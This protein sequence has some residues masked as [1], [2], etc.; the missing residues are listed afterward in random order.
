MGGPD[1]LELLLRGRKVAVLGTTSSCGLN[2][3]GVIPNLVE[4]EGTA[5]ELVAAL[6]AALRPRSTV[7]Y[8][9]AEKTMPTL[10][11]AVVRGGHRLLQI[12]CY[13]TKVISF[14]DRGEI[15]WDSVDAAFVA[16]PSVGH[17]VGRRSQ[18]AERGSGFFAIGPTT[19]SALEATGRP[20][21]GRGG[22]TSG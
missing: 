9:R 17:R 13:R 3:I 10:P 22:D 2:A 11:R 6:L 18:S 12:V 1:A 19:A 21:V 15:C 8:P 4:E 16:A 20:G 5:T 14:L 7:L